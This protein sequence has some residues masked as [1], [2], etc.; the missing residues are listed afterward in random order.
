MRQ[1]W[2][3]SV[4]SDAFL[5]AGSHAILWPIMT[6][7]ALPTGT[8]TF[9]FSDIENSTQLWEQY[10][11]AMKPALAHHDAI[12]HEAVLGNGGHV[13]KTTGDGV[14]AVF[15]AVADA[16]SAAL[17]AQHA[18]S[19]WQETE[20]VIRVRM[21]IHT[22]ETELRDGDYYGSAVNRAARLMSI[23]HGGQVLVSAIS[24]SLVAGSLPA[25]VALRDL[26]QY[27]LRGLSQPERVMQLVGDD[28]PAEFPAL[29][30][31]EARRGNLPEPVTSFIGRDR[32]LAEVKTLLAETRLVTLTGPG[33]T[34]KTRLSLQVGR[35][36]QSEFAHGAWLVELAPL[37]D[38]QMVPAAV[39][40]LW[41][42]RENTTGS[43]NQQLADYLRNKELLL[44]LD[45]CE[46]LVS[47]CAE[48][49]AELL[50]VAPQLTIM[51]SSR[52]GLGIAGET[53]Y[54]LPTLGIPSRD[55]TDMPT[56]QG[57]EAVQLF[58]ERARAAR[59]GFQ[60]TNQNATAVGQIVRRL[61]GIPL[62]I[63]LAAARIKLLPP[64]QLAT[65]L[66][67]RFKLLTGGS[68]TA[69]P[70]QQT[71]RALIDWSYD[72]LDEDE[73]WFFRQMGVFV[74]G[75]T[76]EAAEGVVAQDQSG[77]DAFDLLANLVNKSLI[78]IEEQAGEARFGF[79]ETIRQY[80]REKLF[81]TGE[82]AAARNRH[83]A[84][85]SN[86]VADVGAITA[87]ME[88]KMLFAGFGSL[89]LYQWIEDNAARPR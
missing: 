41:D 43:L 1:T 38:P 26:G 78:T 58:V 35:D 79:L 12:L 2:P 22:G 81:E 85:F 6:S 46:H 52:E 17:A 84:Y 69:L 89:T 36:V 83:L 37:S 73:R 7:D 82:T 60:L 25:G 64:E 27:R 31:D 19:A 57:Y 80:A 68:R 23:G 15:D 76:L 39:A 4:G 88:G 51:A 8:V 34:G 44:I 49:A 72:L 56:I 47:A 59:P 10:P 3:D 24:A 77:L 63:E 28:L 9:L 67:D 70:R 13:V 18:L 45:N 55:A 75:W 5:L 30:T 71:L 48:L 50:P 33:G 16:A 86:V 53:T 29:R 61:D 66:D 11:L 74:G 87:H 62:A 20:P 14:H 42:L 32:A 21:G 40:M 54:H 65:R